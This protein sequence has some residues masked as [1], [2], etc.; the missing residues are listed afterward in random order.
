[1]GS[2]KVAAAVLT[3]AFL[4][5]CTMRTQAQGSASAYDFSERDTYGQSFAASPTYAGQ[6]T[7]WTTT[8]PARAVGALRNEEAPV[9]DAAPAKAK[10]AEEGTDGKFGSAGAESPEQGGAPALPPTPPRPASRPTSTPPQGA[11][12]PSLAGT[13]ASGR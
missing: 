1:M 12:S 3:M 13:G 11:Q 4:A 8:A 5:G 7:S 2:K 6:D 10:G 9:I